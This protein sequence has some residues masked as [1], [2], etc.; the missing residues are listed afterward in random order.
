VGCLGIGAVSILIRYP[1]ANDAAHHLVSAL[2]ILNTERD[3]FVVAEV[4]FAQIPLQVLLADVV[5]RARDP[6]LE[7]REVAFDGVRVSLTANVFLG[8]VVYDLMPEVA[9][10]VSVLARVI[11]N[12]QRLFVE[13]G[14]ENRAQRGG[15]NARQVHRPHRT[16]ALDDGEHGFFAV[17]AANHLAAILAVPVP[18]FAADVGFVR[19]GRLAFAAHRAEHVRVKL[20]HCFANAHRHEPRAFVGDA[21]HPVQLVAGHAFLA[22]GHQVHRQQPFRQRNMRSLANRS[23]R[24]AKP[25]TARAA[26]IPGAMRLIGRRGRLHSVEA[27]AQRA[28]RTIGPADRLKVSGC[29]FVVMEDWALKIGHG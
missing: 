28:I 16:F 26:V 9:V 29:G 20:A 4:E 11:G 13:M 24:R 5:V 15:G 6:A 18:L 7:D 25:A 17:R 3:P 19:L 12:Q 23:H 8:T 10:H 27:A 2:R 1:L 14:N 21:E 22:R